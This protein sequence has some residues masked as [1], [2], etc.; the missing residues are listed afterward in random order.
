VRV[1]LESLGNAFMA[2]AVELDIK[3]KKLAKG[4]DTAASTALA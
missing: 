1:E 3:L 4:S 2:K